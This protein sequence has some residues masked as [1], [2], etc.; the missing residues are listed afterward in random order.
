MSRQRR[1][2]M[3][4]F[5]RSRRDWRR[6]DALRADLKGGS[7]ARDRTR[8]RFRLA[9]DRV[10]T[11]AGVGSWRQ[12]RSFRSVGLGDRI[13]I[14][15]SGLTARVRSLHA[16]NRAADA[17]CGRS[18]RA[19][20]HGPGIRKDSIRRGDF[21]LDPGLHA[22]TDRI[23]AR[24][25]LLPSEKKPINQWFPVRLHHAAAEVGARIVLLRRQA[26]RSERGG[27]CSARPRSADRRGRA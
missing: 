4:R 19:Q 3:L 25:R 23:D 17:P 20:P 24:L 18:L 11:L 14:S 12:E 9:V 7:Q 10:F 26:H 2:R 6:I 5:W 16:Q 27:G 13:Q 1:S 8:Q 21:A 22:P 15:P